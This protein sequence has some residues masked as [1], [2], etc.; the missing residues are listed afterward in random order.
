MTLSL[1]SAV[2]TH[3][4]VVLAVMFDE[5]GARR[6]EILIRDPIAKDAPAE[7]PD[8]PPARDLWP[9]ARPPMAVRPVP[10]QARHPAR[11]DAPAQVMNR[12]RVAA[13]PHQ[14]V[15]L[16]LCGLAHPHEVPQRGQPV[17]H[18]C[19]PRFLAG[20]SG[21][22]LMNASRSSRSTTVLPT[23]SKAGSFPP[24]IFRYPAPADRPV[25]ARTSSMD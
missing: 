20:P 24:R 19:R 23:R 15:D 2:L 3:P 6:W 11:S 16:S 5:T 7:G 14:L 25:T 9:L 13:A 10:R 18:H 12:G 22:G 4:A 21:T 17:I 8:A 1:V